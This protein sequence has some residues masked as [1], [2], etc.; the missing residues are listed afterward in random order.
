MDRH[1]VYLDLNARKYGAGITDSPLVNR[2]TQT[3]VGMGYLVRFLTSPVWR[4]IANAAGDA[5]LQGA[6]HPHFRC[7]ATGHRRMIGR[8]T[9]AESDS[10][11]CS[12]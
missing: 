6:R 10:V 4:R 3:S 12:R 2:S 5:R 7:T 1:F 11:M 8:R 9:C